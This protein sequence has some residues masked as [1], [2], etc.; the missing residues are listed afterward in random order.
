MQEFLDGFAT[1]GVKPAALQSCYAMAENV[2]A[3]TQSDLRSGSG[4]VRIWA[5]GSRFQN[6]HQIVQVAKGTAGSMCFTSSGR[7]L[8]NHEIRV[9]SDSGSILW[10]EMVGEILIKSDC[11]FEGY[12]NR[13]DL[14]A[15]A[16]V[17]G[18]YRTGDLG[19]SLDGE[20]YVVGRKKDLII[21]GGENLYPQDIEDIVAGHPAI[22][23]GRV[24]AVGVDNPD[25]GT[26][27][28]LIIAEVESEDLLVRDGEIEREIRS[29]V[30]AGLGVAAGMVFL[31]PP[32]WIVKSTAGKPA[33]SATLEKLQKEHP[34]LRI[35]S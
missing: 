3:V 25:L 19:F 29:A 13:P 18:W 32:K 33:R 17:N 22:H 20:L 28:I 35:G 11:L 24:I 6:S 8:P 31:K 15:K 1:C 14:T 9:V 23:D 21:V 12:Y 5:D 16:F 30:T 34:E 2:F 4:P 26:Q 7:L 10:D 27:E